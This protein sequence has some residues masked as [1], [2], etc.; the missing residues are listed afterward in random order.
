VDELRIYNRSLHTEEI[1]TILWKPSLPAS[2][3][4]SLVLHWGFDDPM[5]RLER[6]L[7]GN[8]NHGLRGSITAYHDEYF[9]VLFDDGK[10]SFFE[11]SSPQFIQSTAPRLNVSKSC[12]FAR[13]AVPVRWSLD[14]NASLKAVL[15]DRAPIV[16]ELHLD[17]NNDL[18]ALEAG[19]DSMTSFGLSYYPPAAWPVGLSFPFNFTLQLQG[20]GLHTVSVY[21]APL[22]APA[23][24]EIRE[25]IA[26]G[27]FRLLSLGG[28]CADGQRPGVEVLRPPT[29]GKLY[30]VAEGIAI[31]DNK[32]YMDFSNNAEIPG[33]IGS[34]ISEFP[35]AVAH[36]QG[37]RCPSLPLH[38]ASFLS[39]MPYYPSCCMCL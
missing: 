36:P 29:L 4:A 32:R 12:I 8:G 7:S 25:K 39:R 27:E 31:R 2:V 38:N 11:I 30:Q 23:T 20:A 21:P 34:E 6:D 13:P 9:P 28:V 33:L 14:R 22:C 35:A 10:S 16:G 17:N 26:L 37:C 18:H 24:Y 1:Q 15:V 3:A 5:G 19:D